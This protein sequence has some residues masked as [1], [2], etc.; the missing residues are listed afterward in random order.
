MASDCLYMS[1]SSATLGTAWHLATLLAVYQHIPW[2]LLALIEV[3]PFRTLIILVFTATGDSCFRW[4]TKWIYM[5]PF[6][7]RPL[8]SLE[9]RAAAVLTGWVNPPIRCHTAAGCHSVRRRSVNSAAV[10]HHAAVAP[11]HDN[12]VQARCP[13]NTY[14]ALPV[15]ALVLGRDIIDPLVSS[16][17]CKQRGKGKATGT[18]SLGLPKKEQSIPLDRLVCKSL[19]CTVAPPRS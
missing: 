1:C 18:A 17:S 7:C 9:R 13:N 2:V 16:S 15:T 6:C 3:S 10:Q 11:V 4:Y 12:A 14:L 19:Q 5:N 8:L